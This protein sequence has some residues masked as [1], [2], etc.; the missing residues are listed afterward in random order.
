MLASLAA[1]LSL[2]AGEPSEVRVAVLPLVAEGTVEAGISERITAQLKE[3][4][5]RG[6]LPT[7]GAYRRSRA[8]V[9]TPWLTSAG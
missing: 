7:T 8:G 3:G 5:A 1:A 2:A 9:E 4:L 6:P